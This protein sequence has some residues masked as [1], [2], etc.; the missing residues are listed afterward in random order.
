LEEVAEEMQAMKVQTLYEIAEGFNKRSS[1]EMRKKKSLSPEK[2][3]KENESPQPKETKAEVTKLRTPIKIAKMSSIPVIKSPI[4]H[5]IEQLEKRDKILI[6]SKNKARREHVRRSLE[7]I[8][9][10]TRY[11]IAR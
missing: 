6:A 9:A 2:T 10:N 11:S 7:A 8:R 3:Q 4:D 1:L 5:E